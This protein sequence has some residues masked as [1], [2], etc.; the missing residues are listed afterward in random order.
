VDPRSTTEGEVPPDEVA[1]PAARARFTLRAPLLAKLL[2]SYLLVLALVLVPVFLIL[3]SRSR[4]EVRG[5]LQHELAAQVALLGQGLG[6]ARP[7]EL[8]ARIDE[9]L[10]SVPV[11]VTVIDPG[12]HVMGDSTAPG[13]AAE[14]ENHQDRPEIRQAM[15][16]GRGAAIRRSGTTG[17]TMIYA[18]QRFPERGPA[19]GVVRLAVPTSR[20][21]QAASDVLS[22]LDKAG[23]AALS[24]A[25][26][27]SLLAALVVSR[28]LRRIAR[29][30]RA[31]AAGDLGHVVDV[32]S[33]DELGEVAASLEQ[34]AG[35][36]RV[37]LLESGADRMTLRAL[38]DDLPV[39]AVLFGRDRDPQV[40]NGAARSLLQLSPASELDDA[41]RLI[42]Q[43][44]QAEVVTRVLDTQVSEE[45]ELAVPWP[46]KGSSADLRGRWIAVA[47]ADGSAHPV[48]LI[49]P[50]AEPERRKMAEAVVRWGDLLRQLA[51]SVGDPG[52][53]AKLVQALVDMD[54]ARAAG[55]PRPDAVEKVK[56]ADLCQL[57][58]RTAQAQV[59]AGGSLDIDLPEPEA[60]VVES[61]GRVEAALRRLLIDAVKASEPG[62]ALRLRGEQD[63]TRVRLSL[64]LRA[65]A[66]LKAK[67]MANQVAS[68]G[69]EA[70]AI[71]DGDDV[72]L[73]L[74]LPRA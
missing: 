3:R 72:E 47:L 45:Q 15:A 66:P 39:G 11:R 67:W 43:P 25:L 24:L 28:P 26:V 19:L 58:L 60:L 27:L 63:R 29:G 5:A 21:D 49:W 36:L 57:P 48:L 37:R 9:L 56:L 7:V 50:D 8:P 71:R 42:E 17:Q 13:G 32:R 4:D 16:T 46:R 10:R 23:A 33:R 70:G 74:S 38:L 35:Q 53:T 54:R 64:R 14:L 41:R 44:E 73:W 6:R 40:L 69:G 1:A 59:G 31:L 52:L 20:A 55:L 2:L 18:A 12:G 62:A 30:A 68:L 61:G 65:R 34:L 22:F 51:P